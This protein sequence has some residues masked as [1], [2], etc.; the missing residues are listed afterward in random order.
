MYLSPN[1]TFTGSCA[2]RCRRKMESESLRVQRFDELPSA[3]EFA[4][5]I[6]PRNVPAVFSG[7]VKDWKA[8][9][10][11]NPSNGGLD[12][13]QERAGSCTVEAMMSRSAP[14]FYGDIRSHERVPI[15]F[16]SFIGFCKQRM[17][18]E[19]ENQSCPVES[20]RGNSSTSEVEP[21]CSISAF[22]PQQTYLAQ[23]SIMNA[24]N[25]G[26]AQLQILR[27][28]IDMPSILGTRKVASINLWMNNAKAR[29]STHYDPHHNLLCIVA[30]HKQ[31]VLWPPS[32]SH[33]LYPMPL[34]GEASNHSSVALECPNFS[35]YP[36]AKCLMEYSQTV[37]LHAG[38][39][40]FIPEGWFHQVDSTDLTIAVNFWWQSDVM[41]S[42][43]EHMEVYYLRRILRRL[44]DKEMNQMLC[45]TACS[46]SGEREGHVPGLAYKEEA[47][48]S[49]TDTK[50]VQEEADSRG[51]EQQNSSIHDLEPAA[52]QAL[53]EL[54]S[55]VHD[56]VNVDKSQLKVS[57]SGNDS[58]VSMEDEHKN[59][60][61]V[62]LEDDPVAK[63]LWALKPC[64]LRN[65]FAS[66][67]E[68]FPRTLEALVLHLLSPLGAEVLTRKFDELDERT[69][70]EDRNKFYQLFY[71][72]FDDQFAAMEAILNGKELFAQL[73]F[74]SVLDKY[75]GVKLDCGPKGQLQRSF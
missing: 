62:N 74:K 26:Q 20:E 46:G 37:M 4:S 73:A 29:S 30:G 61:F 15:P 65:M 66:M 59:D 45:L 48:Q 44:I 50:K 31:V 60:L 39:A 36:R 70:E 42:M 28:D 34:Y 24:E 56:R 41:L 8:F 7:C 9:A 72:A 23:V 54:V 63:I 19:E 57:A 25:K 64:F 1:V 6:E 2:H 12:Y 43:S 47:D 5:Q 35:A 33:L 27:E 3:S 32:A 17:Q 38:D 55:L 22:A 67:A 68:C 14:V 58:D 16:S 75:L 49:L 10:R 53:H 71:G 40:L 52:L 21:D 69:S 13:L 18:M 11:W 51:K